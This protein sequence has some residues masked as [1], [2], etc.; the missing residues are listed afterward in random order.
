MTEHAESSERPPVKVTV[1]NETKRKMR[2]WLEPLCNQADIGPDQ[3][4][5]FRASLMGDPSRKP[6]KVA[7]VLDGIIDRLNGQSSGPSLEVVLSEDADGSLTL[8][9]WLDETEDVGY[10]EASGTDC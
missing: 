3:R 9:L 6:S 5:D 7:A 4:F 2:L 1:F 10:G 8:T